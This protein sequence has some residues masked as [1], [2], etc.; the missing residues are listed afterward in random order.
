M[1]ISVVSI[2]LLH[3]LIRRCMS[4]KVPWCHGRTSVRTVC[5]V[6]WM[7]SSEWNVDLASFVLDW[8]VMEP[9]REWVSEYLS[10]FNKQNNCPHS[11]V[12]SMKLI[13]LTH[14]PHIHQF[15]HQISDPG[16]RICFIWLFLNIQNQLWLQVALA[17]ASTTIKWSTVQ[18]IWI[19]GSNKREGK[20]MLVAL[21][22]LC[23]SLLNSA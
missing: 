9:L 1:F 4:V 6:N 22:H 11:P 12:I 8:L 5:I 3:H 13:S 17:Y 10:A 19:H 16:L 14:S 20:V 21:T 23:L 7:I 15:Y 2:H 18:G